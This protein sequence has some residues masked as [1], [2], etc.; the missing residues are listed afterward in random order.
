MTLDLFP[1]QDEADNGMVAAVETRAYSVASMFSGAGGMDIGFMGGFTV[2][3]VKYEAL[4]FSIEWANDNNAKACE[5]YRQ[6]C[7][8]IH[9]GDVWEH[10]DGMP[11][12]DVII[13][14]FPCQDISIN[15]GKGAGADGPRTGLYAAMVYAIEKTRP[16]VF[17]AENVK[18]LLLKANHE[19]LVKVL[20]DF[21]SLGYSLSYHLYLAAAYGVPQMRERVFIVG[22][23][24][25]AKPFRPPWPNRACDDWMTAKEAVEDLE[26]L[27]EDAVIN[28]IWSRAAKSPEQGNRRLC[29]FKPATTIRAEHHGNV[30][31]HYNRNRRIS[32]REAARFQSFPDTFTFHAAMRETERQI[33]NAVPPVLAWH[34]ASAVR[35]CLEPGE[36]RADS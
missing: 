22:T 6:N 25:R 10:V 35:D 18:G 16:R 36:F 2:F 32:L 29:A 30:Q 33:G 15:N 7:G 14:G 1:I 24:P 5:T 23:A 26:N 8:E 9:V 28:H 21:S 3:G 4:P 19:S 34:I 17:V 13:G 11:K 20:T 27:E 12:C 31:W